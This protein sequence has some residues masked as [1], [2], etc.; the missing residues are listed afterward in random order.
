MKNNFI[1]YLLNNLFT[2]I[3][4]FIGLIGIIEQFGSLN[5]NELS[6]LLDNNVNMN[7]KIY[8]LLI[9]FILKLN[10]PGYHFLKIELYK[11]LS[12]ENVILFSIMTV[13]INYFFIIF[14]SNTNLFFFYL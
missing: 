4:Y 6:L 1:Y 3:F 9:S 7:F 11:Y 2:N 10:L 8:F 13:Y 14:M 5:L 12:I